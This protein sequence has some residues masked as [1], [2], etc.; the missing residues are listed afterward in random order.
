MLQWLYVKSMATEW[1]LDTLWQTLTCVQ[2]F[3]NNWYEETNCPHFQQKRD[4][5]RYPEPVES[6][7]RRQNSFFNSIFILPSPLLPTLRSGNFP[8]VFN[9]LLLLFKL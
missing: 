4:I 3:S 2:K 1:R 5:K 9:L 8:I 6:N 7:S